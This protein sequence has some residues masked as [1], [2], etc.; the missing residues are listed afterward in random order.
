[1]PHRRTFG[2]TSTHKNASTYRH[3]YPS[4][5]SMN[6]TEGP[7]FS[8]MLVFIIPLMITNLLQVLYN[9]ADMVVV[10]LSSEPDAVG[11]IGL[12]GSF[13]NLII[14][15]FFGFA[16]GA[17]V[18]VARHLGAREDDRAS[19]ATHTALV[20]AV[21]FGFISVGVGFIISRPVLSLM[22]AEGKLL[23]LATT[24]TYIYFLGAPFIALTNYLIAIFRAKGDTRTPLVILSLSGLANVLLNLFFVLFCGL[25]VEGVAIATAIS[26]VVSAFFLLVM[27][28]RSEDACKFSFK[29]LCLD[30]Q[31]FKDILYI[32]LPAG[33]QGSLF[34]LSNMLMQSSILQVNNAIAPPATSEFAPIVRG[35]S[36]A[37]NLETF[38]YTAQNSAYQAVITFTSQNAGA[39][40]YKRIYRVMGWGYLISVLISVFT[41]LILFVARNPLLALYNV[42]DA[43]VGT[44]EHIAYEGAMLRFY[45][46]F[47]P[48]FIISLMEVGCGLVRGLGKA[49]SSTVISL[50]GAGVF[51]VAWIFTVFKYVFAKTC[52][53]NPLEALISIYVSYPISWLL[54]GAIFLFYTLSLLGKR[55]REK[56][57]QEAKQPAT[58]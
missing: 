21:I 3:S 11:A 8:K 4:S 48:Y 20:M 51:R 45:Y 34:S 47:V 2:H 52:D 28:S 16:T 54:T 43:A 50:I 9:A 14:N 49:I 23:E 25:S 26:N 5:K 27:L 58:V 22:G 17:N 15:I 57:E 38:I 29:R 18:V 33:I 6:M 35:N 46:V 12:T 19:R 36:A 30:R 37:A 42:S 31:A 40:S 39:Q 13:I 53:T 55:I 24:Y 1:M 32:G 41:S 7:I 10:S 44:L 56:K